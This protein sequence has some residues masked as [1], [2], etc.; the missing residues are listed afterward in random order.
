MT[1]LFQPVD[2]RRAEPYDDRRQAQIIAS[3]HAERIAYQAAHDLVAQAAEEALQRMRERK[4][5]HTSFWSE[6]RCSCC[7][8]PYRPRNIAGE[9]CPTC[10][11]WIPRSL[12]LSP[13]KERY[14]PRWQARKGAGRKKRTPQVAT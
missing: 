11:E 2:I 9:D 7:T 6:R 8:R 4:V 13:R 5:R 10:V 14:D 12:R 3:L 1:V